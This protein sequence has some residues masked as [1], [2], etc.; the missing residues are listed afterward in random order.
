MIEQPKLSEIP[1][2]FGMD[3]PQHMFIKLSWELNALMGSMS[4]WKDN[5]SAPQSLF[6]A[7]NTAITAWHMTDWLWQ[8]C[9][10]TRTKLATKFQFV[11]E[12]TPAGIKRGLEKFQDA[13][14]LYCDELRVCREIAN[15]SKHMRKRKVDPNIK[16]QAVWAKAV[17]GA[18]FAKPGDLVMSLRITHNDKELD[19]ELAFIEA[20]GFWEKLMTELDV[21]T[22]KARL[23]D[24][25]LKGS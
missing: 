11:F 9:A 3:H 25:I 19:A 16:A 12:E 14:V 10:E 7:F 24:K 21:F 5:E 6:I 8:H 22:A 17:D 20:F 15:G 13:V 4:V 1:N 18:G 23:P 2:V